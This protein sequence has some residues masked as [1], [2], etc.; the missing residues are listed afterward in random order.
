MMDDLLYQYEGN[1]LVAVHDAIANTD[2]GYGNFDFTDGIFAATEYTYDA[3]GNMIQDLNKGITNIT[4]NHLNLPE[5]ITINENTVE[6]IYD[7]N[8]IRHHKITNDNVNIS[9]DYYD[10]NFHY[11]EQE[12]DFIL[13]SEGRIVP[14]SNSV[15]N[16]HRYEYH[17][18]DHQNNLRLA[19]SDL[20]GDNKIDA[21]TEVLQSQDYYPFGMEHQGYQPPLVQIGAAHQ[22]TFQGQLKHEDFGLNWSQF[23]WRNHMPDLGRFFNVD[24]LSEKYSHNSTY[25]FS[26]NK[27]IHGVE[28]EGLEFIISTSPGLLKQSLEKTGEDLKGEKNVTTSTLVGTTAKNSILETGKTALIA[29]GVALGSYYGGSLLLSAFATNPVG[30]GTF[31]LDLA[32]G[33]FLGAERFGGVPGIDDFFSA[34][35][36][37]KVVDLMGGETSSIKGALNVDQQATSGIKGTVADF[38]DF[39]KKNDALGEIDEIVANNPQATFLSESAELLKEGGTITVRG[40]TKNKFFQSVFDGTAEGFDNFEIISTTLD[41]SKEGM[42]RTDGSAI[43]GQVNEIILKRKAP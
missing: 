30:T 42:K 3:N 17:Y 41:V 16:Y 13:T 38:L 19:Y 40:N 39:V 6:F 27:L 43:Q 28:L 15:N 37:K 34:T 10:G 9:N 26:E 18:T 12:L 25:A 7:A 11:A 29:A 31:V 4:Y 36:T 21:N 24:P 35:N 23:K 14:P 20:D 8:G 32:A 5:Q 22:Y 1:R 33:A 2:N